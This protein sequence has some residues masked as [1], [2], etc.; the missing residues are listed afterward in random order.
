MEQELVEVGI[1]LEEEQAL[2][3]VGGVDLVLEE[4][5]ALDAVG[6]EDLVL[7][8]EQALDVEQDEVGLAGG[9]IYHVFTRR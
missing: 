9:S 5:Q 3:V 2:D 7:E 4:E 6:D 8:E 1:G